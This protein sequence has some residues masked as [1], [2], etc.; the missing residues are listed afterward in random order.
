MLTP[1]NYYELYMKVLDELHFLDE[2]FFTLVQSGKKQASERVSSVLNM[3]S[4]QR[5]TALCA[6]FRRLWRVNREE[7]VREPF[8]TMLHKP[9]RL[10]AD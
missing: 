2:F 8:A 7:S 1:R 3:W 6:A 10:D 9:K 4:V 5:E